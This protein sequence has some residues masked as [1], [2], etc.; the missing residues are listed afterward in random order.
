MCAV[1]MNHVHM[2]FHL[3]VYVYAMYDVYVL[4]EGAFRNQR[5]WQ[6]TWSWSYRQLD[7]LELYEALLATEP[8][9]LTLTEIFLSHP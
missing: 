4:Y 3:C 6:I 8:S 7:A 9:L 2:C 1:C 5:G